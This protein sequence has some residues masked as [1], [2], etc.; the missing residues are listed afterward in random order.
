MIP[1]TTGAPDC[2]QN[3]GFDHVLEGMT[4]TS[5]TLL[6]FTDSGQAL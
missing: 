6:V 1:S 3:K 2:A 4:P 5:I